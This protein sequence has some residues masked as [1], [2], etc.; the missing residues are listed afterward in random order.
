MHVCLQ[1]PGVPTYFRG[2]PGRF[3]EADMVLTPS[4]STTWE[5]DRLYM[6]PTQGDSNQRV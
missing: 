6:L 5:G 3:R 4:E 1:H 2:E